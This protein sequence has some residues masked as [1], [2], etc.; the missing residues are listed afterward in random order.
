LDE[1]N[2]RTL[3]DE[4]QV[5]TSEEAYNIRMDSQ[6]KYQ[7]VA[8]KNE[9]QEVKA[10]VR[11]PLEKHNSEERMEK[12]NSMPKLELSRAWESNTRLS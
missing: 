3:G 12:S 4:Q 10:W 6:T 2:S 9:N 11:K 8:Q 5:S 1:D 7:L